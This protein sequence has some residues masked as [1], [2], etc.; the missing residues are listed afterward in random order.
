MRKQAAPLNTSPPATDDA[1]ARRKHFQSGRQSARPRTAFVPRSPY[2]S[3]SKLA[4]AIDSRLIDL[5]CGNNSKSTIEKT[6]TFLRLFSW[7]INR[8]RFALC[9]REAIK[10]FFLYLRR[11]HEEPEGR[12]GNGRPAKEL[13]PSTIETHPRV[14]RAF[15]TFLLKEGWI[16]ASPMDAIPK[17]K[18]PQDQVPA[19]SAEQVGTLIAATK[20]SRDTDG[21]MNTPSK[22]WAS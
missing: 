9:D 18:V 21:R 15:F 10:G 5:E 4:E 12:W 13:R 7:C 6:G 14:L 8:D 11:S 17:P 3:A 20:Q 16:Q 19:L 1:N 22:R 2:L